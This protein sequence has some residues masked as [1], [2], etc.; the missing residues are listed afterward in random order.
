MRSLYN[1][2]HGIEYNPIDGY[3]LAKNTE[4]A[5]V[6]LEGDWGGQIYLVCPMKYVHCSEKTLLNLLKSIDSIEWGCNDGKGRAI[7]FEVIPIGQGVAGGMGGGIVV[8][9]LWLHERLIDAGL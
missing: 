7:C 4:D 1:K 5:C 6:I 8:D 2:A 9:G 3:E